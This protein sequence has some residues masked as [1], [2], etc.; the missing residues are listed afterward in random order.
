MFSHLTAALLFAVCTAVVFGVT[1]RNTDRD[2]LLYGAWV[3]G[4]F[5]LITFGAAWLMYLLNG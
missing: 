1:S 3:F 5:L 4:L 2:R